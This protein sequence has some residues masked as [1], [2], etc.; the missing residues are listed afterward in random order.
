MSLKI[1]IFFAVLVAFII[2]LNLFGRLVAK[3]A[4]KNK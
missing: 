1:F 3:K 4:N 2:A